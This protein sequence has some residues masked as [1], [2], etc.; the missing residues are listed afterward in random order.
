MSAGLIVAPF[1]PVKDGNGN[2]RFGDATYAVVGG[3]M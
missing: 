3:V 2:I 1:I